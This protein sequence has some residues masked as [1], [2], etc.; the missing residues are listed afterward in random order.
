M[1]HLKYDYHAAYEV[2]KNGHAQEVMRKLM[3]AYQHSTPQS[4]GDQYWFW[5]CKNV[6]VELPT[7]ITVLKVDPMDCV[8]FGLT[9]C[10]ALDIIK[11]GKNNDDN[12]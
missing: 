4:I 3:I 11:E 5:N 9:K 7:Y 10:Q 12:N 1:T 2:C 6:P 8:G